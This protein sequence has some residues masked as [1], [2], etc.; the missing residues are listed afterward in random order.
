MLDRARLAALNNAEWCDAVAA[1]HGAASRFEPGFWLN[2][3]KAPPYY[4]N[5]VTLDPALGESQRRAVADLAA[6]RDGGLGVKDSFATLDLADLG[7]AI[8]FAA[9]WL[10]LDAE[11]AIEP[12]L[13]PF[14]TRRM[15][16]DRDL[17]GFEAASAAAPV[18]EP[19]FPPALLLD[20]RIT[21]LAVEHDGALIGGAAL[22][23]S[24]EIAGLSNVFVRPGG[25]ATAVLGAIL[26]EARRRHPGLPLVGYE[27]GDSL[28]LF[29]A[30]GFS[31]AG[32][33]RVWVRG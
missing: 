24:A 7:L 3:G 14:S 18:I 31:A 16:S 26:A 25:D 30:A 4:P 33:L 23:R 27:Q 22:N 13:S 21:F 2:P 1:A 19:V 32:A 15:A 17:A 8:A 20:D 11:A 10:W 12:P 6:S 28:A 9:E 29:R 5:L